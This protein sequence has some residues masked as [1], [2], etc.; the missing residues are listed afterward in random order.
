[1]MRF[2]ESTKNGLYVAGRFTDSTLDALERIQSFLAIPNR[3][4]REE[5]HTT[6]VYSR[7]YVP[8][9]LS[10]KEVPLAS[11][12]WLE[13]WSTDSGNTLVLRFDSEK[14]QKRFDYAMALGASYDYPEYKAHITLSYDVGP[15]KYS[16]EYDIDIIKAC[17][18]AE[19]LNENAFCEHIEKRGDEYVVTNASRTKVLGK[20]KTRDLALQQLRAIEANK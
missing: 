11:K 3:V 15:L 19:D 5:L 1:M 9:R 13:T 10:H 2:I 16:G 4:P 8:Y 20:H 18:Y 12:G 7:N 17:E 6:I 14:L